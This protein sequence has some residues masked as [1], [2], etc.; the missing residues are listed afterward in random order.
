MVT[1]APTMSA[2]ILFLVREA[3]MER[4][5]LPAVFFIP[6]LIFSMPYRK[7]ARPPAR[8]M[9]MSAQEKLFLEATSTQIAGRIKS[10]VKIKN[11]GDQGRIEI[12]FKS[13]SEFDRLVALLSRIA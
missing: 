12:K 2:M 6:V 7:K 10:P 11:N 4:I 3:R 5:L 9:K 13:K 1:K 8:P